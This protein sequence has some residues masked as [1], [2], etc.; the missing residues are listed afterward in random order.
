M[1]NAK[2]CLKKS[3]SIVALSTLALTL[4]GCTTPANTSMVDSS[5]RA[6][7]ADITEDNMQVFVNRVVTPYEIIKVV[8]SEVYLIDAKSEEDAELMAFKKMLH[9]AKEAGADGVMEVRRVIIQDSI[10][11]R[12]T[13][14]PTGGSGIFRDDMDSTGTTLDELTLADYWRGKGTLSSKRFDTVFDRTKLSQKSVVF[15]AKAIKLKK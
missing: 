10:E 6:Y 11:Q 2:F 14:T 3:A 15:K 9:L 1:K 12:P 13:Q 8:R 4:A 5:D 7:F